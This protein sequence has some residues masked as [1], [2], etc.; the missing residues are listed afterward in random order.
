MR[1]SLLLVALIAAAGLASCRDSTAPRDRVPPA[2][3]RGL[4]SVTGDNTVYL[5]WLENTDGDI[6]GY[7]V[8][9]ANCFDC[10]YGLIGTT[11]AAE[12][13]VIGLANGVTRFFAIAAFDHAG[14]ESD[15]SYDNVFD[16][17]RPEGIGATLA[18]AATT[19]AASGWDFSAAVVRAL[20]D[21]LTDVYYIRNGTTDQMVA[22]FT[23]TDIQDAGYTTSLDAVD[24]AP[25]AGW[26]PS[27][28]VELIAGH[29]YVVRS[30]DHY[31]KFRVQSLGSGQLTFDWAYQVDPGNRELKSR[32]GGEAPRVRRALAP[33]P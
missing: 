22:P 27:G 9:D 24:F 8:Y 26:S 29:S 3:P 12:F 1:A 7:R 19:P 5:R 30:G 4:V 13:T 10:E 14:N 33:A 6:A 21:P 23:D 16:T 11:T 15:L 28:I 20:D 32:R 25:V 31:A 17:P 2:A 18:N